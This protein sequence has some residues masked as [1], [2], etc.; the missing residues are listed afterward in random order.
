MPNN[1]TLYIFADNNQSIGP[2][3]LFFNDGSSLIGKLQKAE[4]EGN[5]V[6]RHK[7]E[8]PTEL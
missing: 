7:F 3:N 5:L 1:F 6:W 4:K 8:K 2:E